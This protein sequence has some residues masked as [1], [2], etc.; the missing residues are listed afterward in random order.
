MSVFSENLFSSFHSTCL[1]SCLW[2]GPT[3]QLRDF[4]SYGFLLL[5][6]FLLLIW[7]VVLSGDCLLSSFFLDDFLLGLVDFEAARFVFSC[8]VGEVAS[9][10]LLLMITVSQ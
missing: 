6:S 7:G 8:F 2:I 10:P 1:T 5:L 3:F 9:F 4:L